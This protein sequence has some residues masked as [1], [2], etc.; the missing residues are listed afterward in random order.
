[1]NSVLEIRDSF[2]N[3]LICRNYFALRIKILKAYKIRTFSI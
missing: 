2:L 3:L 1:M